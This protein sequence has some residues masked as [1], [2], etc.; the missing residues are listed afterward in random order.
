MLKGHRRKCSGCDLISSVPR[1]LFV[2]SLI[3]HLLT[4]LTGGGGGG[5]PAIFLGNMAGMPG[6]LHGN[7][8]DYAW[9]PEGLDAII[10]QVSSTKPSDQ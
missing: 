4:G 8:G 6:G 1:M 3:T 9:G 5:H 2:F 10:S 7:P